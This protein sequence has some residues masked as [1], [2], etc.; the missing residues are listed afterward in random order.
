MGGSVISPPTPVGPCSDEGTEPEKEY[1]VMRPKDHGP[2]G[3]WTNAKSDSQ[4]WLDPRALA[5]AM[6]L[7][8]LM[9]IAV[10]GQQEPVGAQAPGQ[11]T[12]EDAIVLAKG[13]NPTF[14]SVQNDQAAANWQVREAYAQFL[15]SAN[16]RL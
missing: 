7:M 12:L 10:V 6:V 9:A 15:P 16:R 5:V 4:D 14:L 1:R 2:V 13:S 3:N 11:L 8:A